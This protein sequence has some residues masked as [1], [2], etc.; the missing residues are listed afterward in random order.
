VV[1]IGF[2]RGSIDRKGCTL[3]C[4]AL[5][6]V[7]IV[8][9]LTYA[10]STPAS[11]AFPPPPPPPT[12]TENKSENSILFG[13]TE[14]EMRSKLA[15]K[16]DKKQ[17]EENL[18]RAREASQLA[19]QLQTSFQSKKSFSSDDNKKLE[20]LEKLTKRLRNEAG[21]SEAESEAK[22]LPP[23]MGEA[24]KSLADMTE[25]LRKEIEKT[26][27]R[28]VSACVIEQANKLINVIQYVRSTR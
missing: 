5:L 6:L 26:P 13:N 2:F 8:P 7:F 25:E 3:F 10:Q 11:G 20:R 21:G 14:S 1:L 22:D 4:T 15:I 12:G 23:N 18:A 28:V 17:Y 24:I 27:R 9:V 19:A 16:E